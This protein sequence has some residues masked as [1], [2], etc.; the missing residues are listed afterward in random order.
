MR[1]K[2]ELAK[3]I[4]NDK[5]N[6]LIN[7]ALQDIIGYKICG[8]GGGGYLLFMT[9]NPQGIQSKFKDLDTFRIKFDNQG[10]RIILNNEK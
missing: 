5:I 4:I 7:R 8:A 6:L 9:E 1:I 2:Q 10:S 3:G